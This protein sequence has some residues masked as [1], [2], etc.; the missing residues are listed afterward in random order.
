[1]PVAQKFKALGAGN[2]F[3][4]C[5]PKVNVLDFTKWTTLSG[6][7]N[8]SGGTPTQTQI[9]NSFAL[10][11]KLFWNAYKLNCV[12]SVE[13]V[14]ITSVDSENDAGGRILT[15]KERIEGNV[16][17]SKTI[18]EI[19][20]FTDSIQVQLN[21]IPCK[22]YKGDVSNEANFIGYGFGERAIHLNQGNYFAVVYVSGY[23]SPEQDELQDT[24]TGYCSVPITNDSS[25]FA[26]VCA[27]FGFDGFDPTSMTALSIYIQN[28]K[29]LEVSLDI[30]SIELYTYPE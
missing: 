29:T 11:L 8:E 20:E 18:D 2:G 7:N 5:L 22:M 26:G 27:G 23:F 14:S 17:I 28:N 13:G 15:P 25:S 19:G 21:I 24:D 1:M 4:Y 30:Q 9:D 16:G 10:A 6:F 12:A 3:P